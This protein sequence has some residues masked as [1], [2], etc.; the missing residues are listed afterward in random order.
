MVIHTTHLYLGYA[1]LK[2]VVQNI[3]CTLAHIFSYHVQVGY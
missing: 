1:F 3:L 2:I